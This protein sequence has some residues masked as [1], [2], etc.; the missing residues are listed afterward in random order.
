MNLDRTG[1]V[2]QTFETLKPHD[3]SWTDVPKIVLVLSTRPTK[4]SG[5]H[6]FHT[7][8]ITEASQPLRKETV[9]EDTVPW[10]SWST[11]W[12]RIS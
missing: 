5:E 9:I 1:Q 10:E 6:V 3:K 11:R 12:Q 7:C 8:V 2:W 4:W